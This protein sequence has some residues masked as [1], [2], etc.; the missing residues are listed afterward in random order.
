[1]SKYA[2]E[3]LGGPESGEGVM[4]SVGS[5]S[6]VGGVRRQNIQTRMQSVVVPKTR[7]VPKGTEGVKTERREKE[8]KM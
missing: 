8:E 4:S 6:G 1:M 2:S 5:P 3:G 7:K